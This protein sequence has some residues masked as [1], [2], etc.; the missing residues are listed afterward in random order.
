MKLKAFSL[1]LSSFLE[2]FP[3]R[4]K[5]TTITDNNRIFNEIHN[6][7]V[8]PF[9]AFGGWLCHVV[10]CVSYVILFRRAVHLLPVARRHRQYFM[11]HCLFFVCSYPKGI[12][13]EHLLTKYSECVSKT[14]DS[15]VLHCISSDT[16]I[17]LLLLARLALFLQKVMSAHDIF[18]D[19]QYQ[20][21]ETV[22]Q[23]D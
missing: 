5:N 16:F 17:Y 7:V 21:R 15:L 14:V 19:A 20:V 2:H 1:S 11:P 9:G 13:I 22:A 8:F 12:A 23:V 18:S 3:R 6:K 4:R 10:I